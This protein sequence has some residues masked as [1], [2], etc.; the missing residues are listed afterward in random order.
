MNWRNVRLIWFREMRDQLRDRRTLFMIAVLPLLMYP[1][2]GSAFLQL[3]QFMKE[4]TATVVVQGAEQLDGVEG[5]PPLLDG[6]RFA[7]ELFDNPLDS[8]R[9][10]VERVAADDP[11]AAAGSL[12]LRQRLADGE[13]DV[14]VYLRAGFADRLVEQRRSLLEARQEGPP[15]VASVLDPPP[16]PLVMSNAAREP[17][18]VAQLRVDRILAR[19][20]DLVVRRNLE[21]SGVPDM[22]TRPFEVVHDDVAP[23]E[24]RD[25]M[26]WAKL[27][28]FVVFVWALTGAFYPAIDLC[29]GEKERGTLET[30]LASP[31][32]RSEIVGGKLLTVMAFSIFTA[33]L[34]LG[35]LACTARMVVEQLSSAL[36]GVSLGIAPPTWGAMLW[37][38]AALVP[39]SAL[40]SALSLACAAYARSTK[41]G[42]YYFMPLFLGAMPLILMPMSPGIELNL[43]N[44]LVPV[45][46]L[47]LLLRTALEGDGAKALAYVLPVVGVTGVCCWLATKWAVSQ[48]KQESVLFRDGERFDL[49]GWLRAV[50]RRREATPSAG[51]AM[52]CVAGV[53]L[54]Q[55]VVR[56]V[57][58][59]FPPTNPGFG[60]LA[61]T[62]VASQV[63]CILLPAAL[64]T[65]LLARNWRRTLLFEHAPSPLTI[66]YAVGLAIAMHPVGQALSVWVQ[67]LYPLSD[68]V[69]AEL[70]GLSKLVGDDAPLGVLLLLFALLPAFCEEVAFRG[71]ILGG[72]R[73]S[74]GDAGAVLVSAVVFGATHTILQ[75][76]LTAAPIGIVLGVL[77]LRSGSLPACVAF[78]AT[79]NALPLLVQHFREPLYGAATYLRIDRLVF[80][81]FG[82]EQLCYAPIVGILGAVAAVFLLRAIGLV[83]CGTPQIGLPRPNASRA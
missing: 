40:F 81:D 28:P 71:V 66:A 18:Q 80:V 79:Y 45:M 49:A 10:R 31:A 39:V 58:T 15:P 59:T 16:S 55:F 43:G 51:A 6:D 30:L 24:V 38:V 46:G 1:L 5:L 11:A 26:L 77:A 4:H 62:L 12:G 54:M 21:A 33:L 41:E 32:R 48:F 44:S 3:S 61:A 7:P 19:W 29:A 83:N 69:H 47:V 27:L 22:A 23:P 42:Q 78:H 14:A 65:L 53:F 56:Q 76:S 75:Q 72:L 2:L 64:V 20:N 70:A 74:V 60:Y 52:A 34:N 57:L 50:W 25:A 35:S 73:K 36:P 37:L 17:S 67:E 8:K 13:F 63:L 82:P 68:A 9:L